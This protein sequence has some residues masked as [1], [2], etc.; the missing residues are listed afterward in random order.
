MSPI[1]KGKYIKIRINNKPKPPSHQSLNKKELYVTTIINI[2]V[3]IYTH[4]YIYIYI[5]IYRYK[6]T[7]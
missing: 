4:I 3:I 5:Y 2:Q 7:P 6:G 1:K